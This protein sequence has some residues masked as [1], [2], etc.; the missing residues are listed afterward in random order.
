MQVTVP[1]K[2][3]I[4]ARPA[5]LIVEKAHQY[6]STITLNINDFC[7]DARSIMDILLLSAPFQA[8]VTIRTSGEDEEAALAAMVDLIEHLPEYG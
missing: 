7:A 2:L 8:Q 5:K 4:H 3:G 6:K 1:N